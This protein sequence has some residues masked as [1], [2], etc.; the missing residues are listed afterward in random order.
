[1][2]K[3]IPCDLQNYERRVYSQNGE[4][5]IL[6]RIF[7]T[8]GTTNKYYVEFGVGPT[9]TQRNT[10]LLRE[11]H[12]WSGLMMDCCASPDVPEI[13][14][15]TINAENINELFAKHRVPE[16]FDLLSIDIDGNDYWVWK[17][18]DEKY[19][20]RVLVLEYNASFPPPQSKTIKYDPNFRWGR[21]DY[22][23]ASLSALDNLGRRKGYS[24]VYCD[25]CGVN[26][27]F[28]RQDICPYQPR[29]IEEIFRPPAFFKGK[30]FG[31]VSLLYWP[32][33]VGHPRDKTR[34]MLDVD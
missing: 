26:A 8:I 25:E 22:Y 20:P 13:K 16:E 14:L 4:D 27:F 18:I 28:I 10:R 23:G 31:M 2:Q 6:L 3:L 7:D 17:A 15:E 21:T 30:Y 29:P 9:G 24:L 12:G 33:G 1:M 32:N 5:G 19:R 34:E 11:K